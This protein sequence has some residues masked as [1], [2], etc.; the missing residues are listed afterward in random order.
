MND[1]NSHRSDPG[2]IQN[3]IIF[4]SKFRLHFSFWCF[5]FQLVSI[6]KQ[7]TFLLETFSR[8]RTRFSWRGKGWI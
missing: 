5:D 3:V 1:S 7:R 2:N 6:Q 8:P 4:A